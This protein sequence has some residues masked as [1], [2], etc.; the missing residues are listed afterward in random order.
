MFEG[1]AGDGDEHTDAFEV[2]GLAAFQLR[3]EPHHGR[4]AGGFD[5]LNVAIRAA[6]PAPAVVNESGIES[7]TGGVLAGVALR[8]GNALLAVADLMAAVV[9]H[10]TYPHRRPAHHVV[11]GRVGELGHGEVP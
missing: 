6:G 10:A 7:R 1:G 2:A 5:R 3:P 4:R 8:R 11:I 9:V